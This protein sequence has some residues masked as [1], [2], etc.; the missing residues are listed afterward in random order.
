[1]NGG[2]GSNTLHPMLNLNTSPDKFGSK[3]AFGDY[4]KSK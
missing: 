3:S 4:S 2:Y 1:M